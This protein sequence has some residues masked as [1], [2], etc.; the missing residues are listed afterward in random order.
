M[1]L[2]TISVWDILVPVITIYNA[3]SRYLWIIIVLWLYTW[4][5]QLKYCGF[6]RTVQYNSVGIQ[7]W[8]DNWRIIS[9]YILVNDPVGIFHVTLTFGKLEVENVRMVAP[10]LIRRNFKNSKLFD[11]D[12]RQQIMVFQITNCM[13]RPPLRK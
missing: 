8:D 1:N 3:N 11:L 13:E 12:L 7:P 2:E 4:C 9:N 10:S 6:S 5:S